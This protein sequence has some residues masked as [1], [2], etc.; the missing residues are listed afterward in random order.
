MRTGLILLTQKNIKNMTKTEYN[1]VA[2]LVAS[3]GN[4]RRGGKNYILGLELYDS[5]SPEERKKILDE[6][7]SINSDR[8]WNLLT[9]QKYGSET[10]R[11]DIL[12][13]SPK[14][15]LSTWGQ[16]ARLVREAIK[17]DGDSDERTAAVFV[18]ASAGVG[19]EK[20][21][22]MFEEKFFEWVINFPRYAF[23]L[24]EF[25]EQSTKIKLLDLLQEKSGVKVNFE[26]LLKAT[27]AGQIEDETLYNNILAASARLNFG[28]YLKK[29]YG[30]SKSFNLAKIFINNN[31]SRLKDF[32]ENLNGALPEGAASKKLLTETL[33]KFGDVYLLESVQKNQE[34]FNMILKTVSKERLFKSFTNCTMSTNR[35]F[36]DMTADQQK[37]F[38]SKILEGAKQCK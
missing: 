36:R 38:L 11:N 9:Y 5:Y 24:K 4:Y 37:N 23:E 10:L 12:S 30:F 32:I 13:Q 14:D 25:F 7:L 17:F 28:D 3:A 21:Q 19:K 35:L 22:K 15:F 34:L 29:R 6:A 33:K 2:E 8:V 26:K 27:C 16:R 1:Q 31:P 18:W 20:L